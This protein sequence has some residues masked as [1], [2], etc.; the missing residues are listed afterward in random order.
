[1]RVTQL[2]FEQFPNWRSNKTTCVQ[3]T[4]P[5]SQNLGDCHCRRVDTHS[6]Y[7]VQRLPYVLEA[8]PSLLGWTH[9]VE[10]GN[11]SGSENVLCTYHTGRNIT[12]IPYHKC[13]LFM[14]LH[15]RYHPFAVIARSVSW[16]VVSRLNKEVFTIPAV[17]MGS[18]DPQEKNRFKHMFTL[19]NMLLPPALQNRSLLFTE[20]R[21]NL[22]HPSAIMQAVMDILGEN[23]STILGV[24][25][26]MDTGKHT[27]SRCCLQFLPLVFSCGLYKNSQQRMCHTACDLLQ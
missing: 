18:S 16:N 17:V 14:C 10:E 27:G 21:G 8:W 19:C 15:Q 26:G 20:G 9:C 5:T 24:K 22:T 2:C 25:G 23:S 6:L 11:G 7:Y 13:L 12:F 1:M 3:D 4:G